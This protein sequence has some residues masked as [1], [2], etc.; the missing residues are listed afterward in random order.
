VTKVAKLREKKAALVADMRA[1]LTAAETEDRDLSAEESA[2]YDDGLAAIA[3]LDTEIGR[4]QAL[5]AAE[6][7]LDTP[8]PSAASRSAALPSP[9]PGP[10]ASREF[11]SFGEFVHATRFRPNDQRLA[12]LYQDFDQHSEQRM[13]TGSSGGFM[14]PEQFR[15]GLLSVDPTEAVVRPRA[16]V[17]PAGTPPD[18][19]I[20]MTALDQTGDTPDNIYGGI[21]VAKTGAVEGGD[22]SVNESDF[23]LRQIKLEPHEFAGFTT[24][25]DKLLR[26]WTAASSL[27]ETQFRR[28]MMASDDREFFN[29]NG[30]G[31]PLGYLNAGATYDV[32]RE[33]SN[34]ITYTDVTEMLARLLMRG[35]SPIWVASQSIMTTLLRMRNPQ[36]SPYN[37]DGA[38]IFQPSVVPGV[39]AMLLGY[40]IVWHERASALGSAGDLS[41]VDLSYYLIKDGSGPIIASS[42][43]VKFTTNKTVFK[44]LW[45]VDGQPW[46]TAPLKQEGG[47]EVSP[48]VALN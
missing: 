27:L 38:L 7:A 15:A 17:I 43:H 4:L 21:T 10:E 33:T 29:G 40:P 35:G 24:V 12:S 41:L 37:G 19:A 23:D 6:A 8:Q 14:V 2:T 3:K 20:S 5:E 42:E 18:A 11:E 44:I 36:G 31:G 45:N 34:T 46:L 26:N 30:I 22:V 47:Y 39:P 16:T 9:P 1:L 13:D 28:A 48:F 32:T 25:T